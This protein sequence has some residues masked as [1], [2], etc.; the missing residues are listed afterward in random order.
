MRHIIYKPHPQDPNAWRWMVEY[1]PEHEIIWG[2]S[3]SLEFARADIKAMKESLK[4]NSPELRG[5]SA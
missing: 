2:T 3:H 4:R 5:V 1:S